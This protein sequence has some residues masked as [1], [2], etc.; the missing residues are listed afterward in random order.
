MNPVGPASRF[1]PQRREGTGVP[2][3]VSSTLLLPNAAEAIVAPVPG[4]EPR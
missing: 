3:G 1:R 4:S 2:G